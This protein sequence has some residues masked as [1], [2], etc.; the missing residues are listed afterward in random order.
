MR[1]QILINAIDAHGRLVTGLLFLLGLSLP[2]LPAAIPMLIVCLVLAMLYRHRPITWHG[3]DRDFDRSVLPWMFALYIIHVIGMAWTTNTGFGLFDLEI[4]FSLA[5]F[6]FLFPLIPKDSRR[7][8]EILQIGFILGNALVVPICSVPAAYETLTDVDIHWNQRFIASYFSLFLHPTYASLYMCMALAML[9]L[10]SGIP[11]VG[12]VRRR[13]V[14]VVLIIGVVLMASKMAWFALLLLVVQIM[15]AKW[16]DRAMRREA[17]AALAGA[18]IALGALLMFSEFAAERIREMGAVIAG[19][20]VEGAGENS[21]GLRLMAWEA[22]T[23]VFRSAPLCGA[24]TGDVK[25]GLMEVYEAR[26]YT[27]AFEQRLNAH[28]QFLQTAAALGLIGLIPLIG[29]LLFPLLHAIR[30][31]DHLAISFLGL[32][33]LNWTVESMIEV[34][35]GVIFVAVIGLSLVMRSVRSSHP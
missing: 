28:S 3:A 29:C 22:A 23:E 1:E 13:L 20:R 6:P 9:Y 16:K 32:L 11:G 8:G 21:S 33:L 34:Q 5:L 30:Q 19:G 17:A 7:G 4:K 15:V 2:I 26:G 24:G 14:A 35:A 31:A 12:A 10:G 18:L 27:S 25:D